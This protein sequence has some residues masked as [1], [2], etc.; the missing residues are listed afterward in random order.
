M[1]RDIS[2]TGKV[3]MRNLV[4]LSILVKD[5]YFLKMWRPLVSTAGLNES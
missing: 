1:N 3:R 5:S 2:I 4:L